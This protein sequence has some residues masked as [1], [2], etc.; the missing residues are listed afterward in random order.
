MRNARESK[1]GTLNGE[2][3]VV[4]QPPHVAAHASE[5]PRMSAQQSC[6]LLPNGVSVGAITES[7]DDARVVVR[8]LGELVDQPSR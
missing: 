3:A 5:L 7:Q 6:D 4:Q 2:D 1:R 8:I